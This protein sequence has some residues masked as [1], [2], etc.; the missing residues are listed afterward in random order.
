MTNE[1]ETII[2]AGKIILNLATSIDGYIATNDGGYDWI[3]GQG[4]TSIDTEESFDFAEFM[5]DIDTVVM[6]AEC[7]RQGMADDY[8]N[9]TVYVVTRTP[10]QDTDNI[11]F[12]GSDMVEVISGEKAK[13]KNIWL[14]GGGQMLDAFIKTDVIDEYIIGIIPTILGKGRRLFLDNNPEIKLKLNSYTVSD[15]VAVVTYSK[16]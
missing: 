5:D 16:R 10:K 2:M 14:F 7:Y 1:E 13:G 8:T 6:G 4:D 3:V 12:I 9:K 15:G 11:K